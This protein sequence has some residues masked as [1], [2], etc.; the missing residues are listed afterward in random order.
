MKVPLSWLKEYLEL[1]ISPEEI[2]ESLTLAGLEVDKVE[3]STFSFS[4]V[5]I[6]KVL[7][8]QPHPNADRLQIARVFDGKEEF[9]VVCGASNCREGLITAFAKLGASLKEPDGNIWKIKKSKIR[10][11]ESFGMLCAADELGLPFKKTDGILELPHSAP[12]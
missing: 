4:G 1:N 10:D 2:A 12:L 11:I 8:T 6:A 9:Q 3:T 5:V 7:E